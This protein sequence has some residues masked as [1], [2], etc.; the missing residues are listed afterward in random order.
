MTSDHQSESVGVV[1]STAWLGVPT[2]YAKLYL[3]G[4]IATAKQVCRE[5]CMREGLCVTVEPCEYIYTGG[6]ETG[7]C[8]GLINYPRFPSDAEKITAR[9]KL[10]AELLMTRT[11]QWS[12]LVMTPERTEWLT[13][14]KDA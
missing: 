3:A 1:S 14:R 10:L 9:A 12:A 6:Q 7:Y 4:D 13:K 5:E 2:W 11:C 8:V